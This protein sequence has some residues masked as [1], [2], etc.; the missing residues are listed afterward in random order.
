MKAVTNYAKKTLIK[1]EKIVYAAGLH[2]FAYIIPTIL[3]FFSLSIF[4]YEEIEKKAKDS[5]SIQSYKDRIGNYFD[6]REENQHNKG[7]TRSDG[8]VK[9]VKSMFSEVFENIISSLPK[10]VKEYLTKANH[11]RL[12]IIS[13]IIFIIAVIK[14]I[15]AHIKKIST[16]QVIT[17]KKILYKKGFIRVNE[18]EI[19]LARVEGVK[20][21]QTALDRILNRGNVL[22]NGI[23]MEQIE[24]K[25]ISNPTKFRNAA[26]AA[27]DKFTSNS[28]ENEIET[29]F[30]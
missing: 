21:Y 8:T 10:D 28:N 22:I 9:K 17:T 27:I 26:Y 13:V 20:I 16:E 23:G 29:Q 19:P 2:G 1:G 11:V 6:E 18:T 5:Q 15:N 30:Y 7:F 4:F 14:L 25:K 12:I 24:I 3:I